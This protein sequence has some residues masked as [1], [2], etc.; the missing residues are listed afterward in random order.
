M[1]WGRRDEVDPGAGPY[2]SWA[3]ALN[4]WAADPAA[5]LDGLP[6]LTETTFDRETYGRFVDRIQVAVRAFMAAWEVRLNTALSR[7][8]TAH[9]YGRELLRLRDQLRP[10]FDLAHHPGLPP[11]IRDALTAAL[12]TDIRS[13]QSSLEEAATRSTSRGRLEGDETDRLLAVLRQNSFL[14]VLSGPGVAGHVWTPPSDDAP[15]LES[16]RA[17][18]RRILGF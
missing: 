8:G 15:A 5:T 1:A 16:A 7:V 2:E 12:D 6:A 4:R 18:Q 9:D 11:E 17:A 13:L 10:R 14:H 3:T